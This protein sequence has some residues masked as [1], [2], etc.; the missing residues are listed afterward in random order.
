M[1][2]WKYILIIALVL[3][4]RI[5]SGRAQIPPESQPGALKLD[6]NQAIQMA[7][8]NYEKRKVSQSEVQSA[9]GEKWQAYSNVLPNVQGSYQYTRNIAKPSLF[10]ESGQVTVGFD[11]EHQVEVDLVQPL[12]RFGG[13]LQGVKAGQRAYEASVFADDQNEA[14]V[15][16]ETR[17]AYYTMLVTAERLK[18]AEL[19][20]GQSHE[21]RHREEI[22][23]KVGE[24][25]EFDFNRAQLEEENKQANLDQAQGNYLIAIETMKRIVGVAPEQAIDLSDSLESFANSISEQKARERFESSNPTVQSLQKTAESREAARKSARA[26][27]LP[28]FNFFTTFQSGGQSSENLIPNSQESYKALSLG[29]NIDIP[30]FDGMLSLG[31]Y[32]TASAQ[33]A[34]AAWQKKLTEKNLRLDLDQAIIQA[35]VSFKKKQTNWHS[36]QLAETLF[37][38]ATLRF[39]NGILSYIDLKDIKNNLETARLRY[40]DS[41]YDYVLSLAKI[42]QI[43]GSTLTHE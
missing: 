37:K 16:Y 43:V 22:R 28:M 30:V 29:L 10:F 23:Y 27:L 9:R 35:Q 13:L 6:M 21:I 5:G 11:N 41:L 40:L 12:T 38:Q 19:S 14:D 2:A 36:V 31:K 7:L 17:Q 18:V 34:K 3:L 8:G 42:E 33:A 15:I 25:P 24:I 1:R 32:K 4:G 20:L 26:N 39:Q